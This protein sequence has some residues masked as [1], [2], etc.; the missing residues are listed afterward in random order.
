MYEGKGSSTDLLF[1]LKGVSSV[2]TSATL[3]I[4]NCPQACSEMPTQFRLLYIVESG[5]A[6]SIHRLCFDA[7]NLVLQVLQ[8][9]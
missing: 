4:L 3:S 5:R 7:K 1:E 6:Q 9:T 8:R 2:A